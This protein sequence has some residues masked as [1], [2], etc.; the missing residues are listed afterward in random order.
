[1]DTTELP[2]TSYTPPGVA[3][4]AYPFDP[5]Y[6]YDLDRLL[7][8]TPPPAPPDFD[9]FWR[10]TW[11]ANRAVPLRVTV[12]DEPGERFSGWRVQVIRYAVLGGHRVGAWLVSP[13]GGS[14]SGLA[15]VIGHGY[16]GRDAP[17]L[18]GHRCP[19]LF[20]CAPG[21]HLSAAPG[22]PGGCME[23]VVHGI[24]HRE[25][26]LIRACVCALWSA[27]P[28]LAEV[29]PVAPHTVI[30]AGGSFGGGL[31]ALALPW[32]PG[33]QAGILPVPTFGHHP[34]RLSM[35]CQGSG[36]AV[37]LLAQRRPAIR[38][39]LAYYDAAVAAQRI[40]LPTLC[41]PARFDP[42]VPPPGQFA[43]SNA[44]AANG[45][46]TFVYSAGHVEAYTGADEENRALDGLAESWIWKGIG[47]RVRV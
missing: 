22:L 33:Y 25:T 3:R 26:Y 19:H 8:I 35:P 36:E 20:V 30:Y 7:A 23:H 32:E 46:K 34:L 10:D 13:C 16:G 27:V 4:N 45:G 6:G 24:D 15:A 5:A 2:D 17:E 1:M 47:N 9:A 21:F 14:A 12:E 11:T 29:L 31:G 39:V 43:V 38:D 28:V 42:A 37:R 41:A 40:H 18:P 44:L